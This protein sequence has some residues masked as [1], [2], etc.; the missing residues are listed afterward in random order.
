M[1][2]RFRPLGQEFMLLSALAGDPRALVLLK[3]DGLFAF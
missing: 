1:A 3:M 2:L